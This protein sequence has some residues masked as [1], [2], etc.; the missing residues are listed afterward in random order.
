MYWKFPSYTP[1]GRYK[2]RFEL[3]GFDA[4][5]ESKDPNKADLY[6]H[7][8]IIANGLLSE[9]EELKVTPYDPFLEFK[10]KGMYTE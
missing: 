5:D 2:I 9:K 8:L 3:L 1:S 4:L 6:K 7:A 10:F